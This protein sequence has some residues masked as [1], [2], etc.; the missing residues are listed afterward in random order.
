MVRRSP[1]LGVLTAGDRLAVWGEPIAHSR[2]PQLHAAAYARLGWRWTYGRRQVA[3]SGFDEAL[4]SLDDAWRGLSLTYPLKSVAF[5]AAATRDRRAELTA[6]VNTLLLTPGG[7]HGFNT[8]VGGIVGALA[9]EGMTAVESARIIGAGAT[10]TSALVA[11][12]ELGAERVEVVARRPEAAAALM[13]LGEELGVGVTAAPLPQAEAV[14]VP[15]TVAT[16][17]GDAAMPDAAARTLA[18]SGG[19]LLDVVYGT[20]PTALATVWQEGGGRAVPGLGMLLHQAVLQMRVFSTGR[21]DEPLPD[22]ADVLAVMRRA[23]VGD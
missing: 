19:L 14:A 8:D 1:G 6:A 15:L 18:T 23:A 9:D 10:A 17:P 3:A 2:S 12:A 20:W 5:A 4:A 11:L 13:T 21:T 22:E 7:P 16:L